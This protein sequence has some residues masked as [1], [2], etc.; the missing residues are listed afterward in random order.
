MARI[1][2]GTVTAGVCAQVGLEGGWWMAGGCAQVG[3]EMGRWTAGGCAQVVWPLLSVLFCKIEPPLFLFFPVLPSFLLPDSLPPF[4]PHL[5]CLETHCPCLP[6][7][8]L[9]IPILLPQ[10]L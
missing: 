1:G 10:P 7:A 8:E 3:L 2:G 6:Q 4:L 9:K 5:P